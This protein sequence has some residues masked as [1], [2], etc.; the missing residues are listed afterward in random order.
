MHS[1]DAFSSL[2]PFAAAESGGQDA[3]RHN[4][5]G[6]IG[7]AVVLAGLGTY[8]RLLS[9]LPTWR[10]NDPTDDPTGIRL[11]DGAN[12]R[13]NSTE[14][15]PQRTPETSF[16]NIQRAALKPPCVFEELSRTSSEQP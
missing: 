7:R 5:G 11:T 15:E 9:H 16:L 6:Y 12:F 2:S 1:T 14:S 10:T 8:R 3:K 4:G 13:Q